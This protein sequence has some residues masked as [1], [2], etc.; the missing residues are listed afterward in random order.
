MSNETAE[1]AREL[2]LE[3]VPCDL[4]TTDHFQKE[5]EGIDWEFGR[6]EQFTLV[7]CLHCGLLQLNPRPAVSSTPA[8]YPSHYGFYQKPAKALPAGNFMS[9][10][11]TF[12]AGYC[13]WS[14][15]L[16][17]SART[18]SSGIPPSYPY[19]GYLKKGREIFDVGC[20]TGCTVY[21]YGESGSLLD[22]KAKGWNPHGCEREPAAAQTGN[23][24][25][26]DIKVG[27]IG[28]LSLPDN[29]FDSVRFNHVLEHSVSPM[30][31][32]AAAARIIKPGGMV[33]ISGPNIQSAAFFLFHRQWSGLDLPRHFYQFTPAILKT[34]CAA[35][36]LRVTGEHF[37]S[38]PQDFMHSFKHFL[39]SAA[40][41]GTGRICSE[42]NML[43]EVFTSGSFQDI[44]HALAPLIQFFNDQRLGDNYTLVAV[45]E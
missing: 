32:L 39:H 10:M 42:T 31:D 43:E 9:R 14:G 33:L 44:I 11:K 23:E 12:L 20:A 40:I 1:R 8:I 30:R 13:T 2:A 27:E 4:C 22:L 16:F 24:S 29:F 6:K 17:H 45:K 5:L 21:P 18:E 37:D 19:Y 25:G 15:P 38:I 28:E 41:S 35:I 36:G 26:L 7:K 3:T 34:Y